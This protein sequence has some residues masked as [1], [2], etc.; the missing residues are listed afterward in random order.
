[1]AAA[2]WYAHAVGA[3]RTR[4]RAR[5]AHPTVFAENVAYGFRR[6]CLAVRPLALG[7]AAIVAVACG[8]TSVIIMLTSRHVLGLGTGPWAFVATMSALAS[9]V[10]WRV[11]T[12]DW[13]RQAAFRYARALLDA[14]SGL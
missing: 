7:L 8:T 6:N 14:S 2:A 3:L 4:T 9:L 1:M 13:V 5:D 12:P 11:A 10:W